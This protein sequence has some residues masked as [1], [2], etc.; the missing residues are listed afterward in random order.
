MHQR[1]AGTDRWLTLEQI[2]KDAGAARAG[3]K[4]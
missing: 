4:R 1:F 3:V 2:A